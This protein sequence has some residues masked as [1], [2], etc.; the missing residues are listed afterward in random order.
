MYSNTIDPLREGSLQRLLDSLSDEKRSFFQSA[1]QQ[2]DVDHSGTL[3]ASE[4]KEVMRSMGRP[5]SD[6]QIQMAV[7][8]L[9]GQLSHAVITFEQFAA[10]MQLD[11]L[12]TPEASS[13]LQSAQVI[14]ILYFIDVLC[15]WSYIA[16]IR[17]DELKST[18]GNQIAIN[19][20]FVPV[21]GDA[22]RKLENRWKDRGGFEGYSNH[23]KG[24]VAKFNHLTVHPDVWT[25]TIPRSSTS[26]H[27]FL[28]AIDLL[29]IQ[30]A[31]GTGSLCEQAIAAM[32]KAFFQD[33]KDVSDRR[34]QLEIAEELRLPIDP[35]EAQIN[36]G[37]AYA[38]LSRD[39]E[40]VKEHNVT[41]SPTMI[42]NEGRQRLNGNVGYRVI[43][44]NIRE[45]IHSVPSEASWC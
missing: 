22:H 12:G 25:K 37:A 21:F 18:F 30:E 5:A 31:A 26:C 45:L 7:E 11:L 9:T 6:Q 24:V 20:H 4:L 1:F 2:F 38:E 33:L 13:P 41:V 19:H 16:Q 10:L 29:E 35:L 3:D 44:A 40:L 43:E 14:P 32:R 28:K 34:V 8:T 36:S 39:F 23:V 17:I 42:F 15:I 27:L